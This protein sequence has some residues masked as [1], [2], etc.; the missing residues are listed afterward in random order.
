MCDDSKRLI[1]WMD[2]ELGESE[3]A[4]VEQHVRACAACQECV[5]S[6]EAASR[7]FASYYETTTQA[8]P[9]AHSRKIAPWVP[10]A[11]AIATVAAML[12]IAFVVRA[13]KQAPTVQQA[14]AAPAKSNAGMETLVVHP[15][16]KQDGMADKE[17]TKA[18]SPQELKRSARPVRVG[19]T[20]S[21]A[22]TPG[23]SDTGSGSA[24]TDWAMAEPAIQIAIPADAMFP[25]GAVPEGVT[26]IANV[27]L[28][29]D[30][31]VQGIRLQP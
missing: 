7:D 30:G 28:G 25:P 21:H 3:S 19:T 8:R 26:Y 18:E 29:G 23:V 31:R 12:V 10:V 6:Y 15:P 2:G 11:A 14:A 24:K 16:V 13:A 20:S 17:S 5:A 1:A 27:S 22:L 9:V 4:E